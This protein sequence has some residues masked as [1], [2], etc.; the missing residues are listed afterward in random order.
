[1]ST[2]DTGSVEQTAGQPRP[3]QDERHVQCRVVD[4]EAVADLAVFAEGFAVIGRDHDQCLCTGG[5]EPVE[6]TAD[7]AI[8]LGDLVVVAIAQRTSGRGIPVGRM[9]FEEMHP[10]E[11][12]GVSRGPAPRQCLVHRELAGAFVGGPAVGTT[13]PAVTVHVEP[14]GKAEAAIEGKRADE[15]ARREAG[16]LE[17]GGERRHALPHRHAVVAGAVRGRIPSAQHRRV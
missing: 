11:R 13:R 7:L 10:Q 16:R 17:G 15:G 2:S 5:T 1:M 6:Q 3:L 9:R 8:R 12:A 4:E 14:C